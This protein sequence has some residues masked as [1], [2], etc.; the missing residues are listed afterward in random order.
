MNAQ[1]LHENFIWNASDPLVHDELY[2]AIES[3]YALGHELYEAEMWHDASAI[4]RTML[5]VVPH[6]MRGWLGL[7]LCHEGLGQPEVSLRLYEQGARVAEEG[8]L[9][10]MAKSRLVTELGLVED[11]TEW[12]MRDAP[13][14]STEDGSCSP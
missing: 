8:L 12:M 1:D 4:F 3:L 6:D 5:M 7:G 2:G 13:R 10:R 14:A 11:S 9:C